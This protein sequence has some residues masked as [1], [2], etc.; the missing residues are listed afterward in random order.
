MG[1]LSKTMGKNHKVFLKEV[2]T[3]SCENT[4]ME[5]NKK[6]SLPAGAERTRCKDEKKIWEQLV[7]IA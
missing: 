2:E 3:N 6:Y 4:Y 1:F 7:N 5:I